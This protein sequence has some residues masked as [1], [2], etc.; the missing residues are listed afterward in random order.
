MRKGMRK[1]MFG[2]KIK[3]TRKRMHQMI[4]GY[5]IKAMHKGC[6]SYAYRNA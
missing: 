3:A 4:F 1:M 6:V 2:Y 5:K